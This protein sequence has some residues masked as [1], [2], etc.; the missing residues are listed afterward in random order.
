MKKLIG[1]FALLICCCAEI[2]AQEPALHSQYFLNPYSMNPGFAGSAGQ[3]ELVLNAR[4]QWIGLD[5]G[6]PIRYDLTF[7]TPVSAKFAFGTQLRHQSRGLV[8]GSQ[9]M[10]STAYVLPFK[11]EVYLRFGL[12]VGGSYN[13]IDLSEA[14]EEQQT[15]L[16]NYDTKASRAEAAFGLHFRNKNL[17]LGV[18]LPSLTGIQYLDNSTVEPLQLDPLQQWL[19]SAS[20]YWEVKPEIL[21][22]EPLLVGQQFVPNTVR[23][24]GGMVAYFKNMFWAGGTYRYGYGITGLAG[25]KIK[26]NVMLGYAYE[27]ATSIEMGGF[28]G[29]HEV[30][31]KIKLGQVKDFKKVIEHKP[32]FSL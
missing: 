2:Q 1:I 26:E 23:Y 28:S 16:A 13:T 9:L 6:A 14:T 32:R 11:E 15:Y 24:E 5:D 7:H 30:L 29:S 12:A 10:V 17:N 31:F 27:S 4:R 18:T 20:Y 21:V 8:A 25:L 3:S 19:V 22:L